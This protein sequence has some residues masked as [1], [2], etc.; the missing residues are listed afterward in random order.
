MSD[1]VFRI[2]I[3]VAVFLACIAFL[4]QAGV[5]LALYRSAKKLEER[6]DTM[7]KTVT[8]VLEKIGPMVDKVTPVVERIAPMMDRAGQ[9]MERMGPVID[10]SAEV[11]GKIGVVVQQAGPIVDDV[12][13][14]LNSTNQIIVDSRP[15]ISEL[16]EEAVLVARSAREQVQ[17]IGGVVGDF[18][19][20][21]RARV[22]QINN[23]VENTFEQVEHVGD[24][25][26]RAVLRPVREANGIAAGISAA[27]STLVKGPRK[28]SPDNVT[29]DEEMFI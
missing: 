20:R 28:S 1:E 18:S 9:T 5:V 15:R 12:R 11:I 22:D 29:Q 24:A 6:V 19:H 26:K 2:V 13:R 8:P 10:K 7:S 17:E 27:M 21:A 14:V 3:S 16:S 23:S 25:M 4:V